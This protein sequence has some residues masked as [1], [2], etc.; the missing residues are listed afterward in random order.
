MVGAGVVG[1]STAVCLAEAG[2]S[3]AVHA[4]APPHLTTSAG[5][6]AMWDPYLVHPRQRVD[7]WGAST[8][9][10]LS[11]LADTGVGVRMALGTQQSRTVCDP[12]EW[13]DVLGGRLCTPSELAPGYR[14]G[15]RYR[16]PVVDMPLFLE[17]LHNRLISAGGRVATR[18]YRT[19]R[20]AAEAAPMVVN[21]TGTGAR[22]LVPDSSLTAVQGQLVVVSNPGI[23]EFFCDDTPDSEELTYIYPHSDTVVL[24]G[25]TRP[26]VWDLRPDADAAEAIFARCAAVD[27]RLR[28]ASV[29][30]HRVGLRPA[31]PRVRLEEERSASKGRLV[32]NYGHGGAGLTLSWGCAREVARLVLGG[33]TADLPG[34]TAR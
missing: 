8:Y 25:T 19:L 3:V 31:R 18:I 32:H 10:E 22:S 1:L 9:T 2:A 13:L 14:S 12:P 4:A 34:G 28:G 6:G 26:D 11:R 30:G 33:S 27:G 7:V 23:S 5:A 20:E 16:A 15:W 17:H 24:G 21:C 29:L